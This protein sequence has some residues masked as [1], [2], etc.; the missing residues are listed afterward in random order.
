[1]RLL[2]KVL[3][4]GYHAQ[5]VLLFVNRWILYLCVNFVSWHFTE[6]V[7][8]LLHSSRS[9][10]Y[11]ILS[12]ANKDMD[13]SLSH[14]YPLIFFCFLVA[15]RL[16]VLYGIGMERVKWTSLS[17]LILIWLWYIIYNKKFIHFFSV[18]Q[19]GGIYIFKVC[20]YDFG[21]PRYLLSS[22]ISNFINL[23]F[24]SLSFS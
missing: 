22:F 1:M 2:W 13:I 10:L 3:F 24:L 6:S 4:S 18:F 14:L 12:S 15:L 17:Y 7:Y 16:Q 9:F 19:L 11:K 5:P 23:D 21:F 20:P 8:Q